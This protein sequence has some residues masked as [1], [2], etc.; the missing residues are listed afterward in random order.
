MLGFYG[1]VTAL[2]NA[3]VFPPRKGGERDPTFFPYKKGLI[4]FSPSSDRE[5]PRKCPNN[6]PERL[7]RR[8]K[9][10]EEEKEQRLRHKEGGGGDEK[11][12]GEI[13]PF[14]NLP[15]P[16]FHASRPPL[17]MSTTTYASFPYYCTREKERGG[18]PFLLPI[19]FP[20]GRS[21]LFDRRRTPF[22]VQKGKCSFFSHFLL[23]CGRTK[24][25]QRKRRA[26]AVHKKRLSALR[27][28]FPSP[29][30]ERS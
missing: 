16:P 1:G 17:C 28:L 24:L 6:I 27:Q 9:E 5:F 3:P 21:G 23:L 8:E 18:F 22:P 19:M 12:R 4:L 7:W 20:F 2:S 10:E 15:H 13:P 25:S 30:L 14:E 11:E 26:R 29:P